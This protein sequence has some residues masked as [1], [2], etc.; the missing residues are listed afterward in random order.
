M[1]EIAL[2]ECVIIYTTY[3]FEQ[4]VIR[5]SCFSVNSARETGGRKKERKAEERLEFLWQL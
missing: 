4:P 3:I 1:A 2:C 5:S